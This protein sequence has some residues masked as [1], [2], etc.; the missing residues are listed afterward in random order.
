MIIAATIAT[1]FAPEDGAANPPQW[2]TF[3]I[4]AMGITMLLWHLLEIV[5]MLFSAKNRAFHDFIAGT[6]VVRIQH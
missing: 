5:T 3:T 6:V 1:I 4:I 2:Y